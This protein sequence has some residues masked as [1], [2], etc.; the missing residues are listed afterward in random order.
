[1]SG[2][3]PAVRVRPRPETRRH[4]VRHRPAPPRPAGARGTRRAGP[5]PRRAPSVPFGATRC[6]PV[7]LGAAQTARR[8]PA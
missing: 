3:G 8:N 5:V 7:P 4:A 2:G 1:P 6:R